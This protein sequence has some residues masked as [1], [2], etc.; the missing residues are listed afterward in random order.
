MFNLEN[1]GDQANNSR[2][3][4]LKNAA[5]KQGAQRHPVEQVQQQKSSFLPYKP[6]KIQKQHVNFSQ[7]AGNNLVSQATQTQTQNVGADSNRLPSDMQQ[8]ETKA[9]VIKGSQEKDAT[10]KEENQRERWRRS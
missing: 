4:M 8:V 2:S 7:Q 5:A 10:S 6:F 3:N 9:K 1:Q